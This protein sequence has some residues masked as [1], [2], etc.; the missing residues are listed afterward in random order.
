V[1]TRPFNAADIKTLA[2]LMS[3][4]ASWRTP[5]RS[6]VAGD[7]VGRDAVFTQFGRHG[8]ETNGTFKAE[9]KQVFGS[10]NRRVVAI[11]HNGGER[12]GKRL[13]TDCCIVFDVRNGAALPACGPLALQQTPQQDRRRV[14][15]GPITA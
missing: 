14:P 3:E 2:E 1:A 12:N 8:G 4:N 5:S 6:R 11:H 7:H 10:D 9:L 13:D 15:R